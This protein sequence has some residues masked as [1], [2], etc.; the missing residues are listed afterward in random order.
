MCSA[1]K[2]G[3]SG[4]KENE[5]EEKEKHMAGGRGTV[6]SAGQNIPGKKSLL[7]RFKC[8]SEGNAGQT[9]YQKATS[10]Q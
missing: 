6:T 7:L 4:K 5:K 9:L 3:I 8:L 2:R 10:P 1:I